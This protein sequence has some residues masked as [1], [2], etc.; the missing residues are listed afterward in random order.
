MLSA[1]FLKLLFSL[2]HFVAQRPFQCSRTL[3][4]P[5]YTWMTLV[6]F[7]HVVVSHRRVK[8]TVGYFLSC[9]P[10]RLF[11]QSSHSFEP[12]HIFSSRTCHLASLSPA[13]VPSVSVAL[14]PAEH[15]L[16]VISASGFGLAPRGRGYRKSKKIK[17][18]NP[19]KT[20]WILMNWDLCWLMSY[21]ASVHSAVLA[22]Y[23]ICPT[24]LTNLE[25]N[26]WDIV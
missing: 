2:M 6:L 22:A 9:L 10:R 16:C 21:H 17:N 12:V 23:R 20:C 15:V 13:A 5:F 7:L 18:K 26:K 14:S 3:P 24:C 19:Q 8:V 1:R 4:V 11:L 25:V